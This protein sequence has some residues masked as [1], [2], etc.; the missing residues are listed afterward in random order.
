LAET[1]AQLALCIIELDQTKAQLDRSNDNIFDLED[2]INDV[3]NERN[4][5]INRMDDAQ[6]RFIEEHN[7]RLAAESNLA[8]AL[9][10]L[11]ELRETHAAVLQELDE[12]SAAVQVADQ[13]IGI[14]I[15][16]T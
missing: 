13:F 15:D 12:L 3:K 14:G 11:A 2:E 9:Q 8:I 4:E 7:A 5:A 10:A 16:A 1:K 6:D